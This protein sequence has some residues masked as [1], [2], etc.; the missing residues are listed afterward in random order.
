MQIY[1]LLFVACIARSMYVIRDESVW[2][3]GLQGVAVVGVGVVRKE[4]GSAL[5]RMQCQV[6]KDAGKMRRRG[7]PTAAR[8]PPPSVLSSPSPAIGLLHHSRRHCHQGTGAAGGDCRR[9][10][11]GGA[12]SACGC[13]SPLPLPDRRQ[14]TGAPALVRPSVRCPPRL[15][16]VRP[17]V[18]TLRSRGSLLNRLHLLHRLH[19]SDE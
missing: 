18:F 15:S 9:R 19:L 14:P 12:D 16:S 3:N 8:S 10:R 17:S 1:Y 4:K 2:P 6:R 13:V 7:Y 5:L 11:D